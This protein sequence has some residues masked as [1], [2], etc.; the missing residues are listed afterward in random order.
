MN[1]LIRKSTCARR[2]SRSLGYTPGNFVECWYFNDKT[3]A[4]S[5]APLKNFDMKFIDSSL[6]KALLARCPNQIE[7]EK[8][9]TPITKWLIFRSL[10][11]QAMEILQRSFGISDYRH[12]Q[13]Y[14]STLC[15][16]DFIR[17]SS[18]DLDHLFVGVRDYRWPEYDEDSTEGFLDSLYWIRELDS[19][20][21]E[22]NDEESKNFKLDHGMRPLRLVSHQIQFY[23]FPSLGT[24][25]TVGNCSDTF[26]ETG[27][28]AIINNR[29]QLRLAQSRGAQGPGTLLL[30]LIDAIADEVI[31]ALDLLSDATNATGY[32]SSRRTDTRL[33]SI[34]RSIKR[35]LHRMLR[36]SWQLHFV[37]LELQKD[38][39][40]L[41]DRRELTASLIRQTKLMELETQTQIQHCQSIHDFHLNLLK[42]RLNRTLF[43]LTL[44][45]AVSIPAQFWTGYFGMNFTHLALLQHHYGLAAFFGLS[46]LSSLA[47]AAWSRTAVL[48]EPPS[49]P[50]P[51]TRSSGRPEPR[52]PPFNIE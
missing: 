33:V 37:Y 14:R 23:L 46:L 36:F 11:Y 17:G 38:L 27:R 45:S 2:L 39:H 22:I 28:R 25:L 20:L 4:S 9:S 6:Q 10:D 21:M 12:L 29:S 5:S 49:L 24:L 15:K 3:S 52:L 51:R 47:V 18:R 32:I 42:E 50:A 44:V 19:M 13:R 41:V 7:G 34:S 26:L 16:V 8:S 1:R 35:R 31:P 43:T 48:R 40:G 30:L